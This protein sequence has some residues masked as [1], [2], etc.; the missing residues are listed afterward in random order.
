MVE[1][2]DFSPQILEITYRYLYVGFVVKKI[3][4]R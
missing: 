1:R 2:E 3:A 4:K